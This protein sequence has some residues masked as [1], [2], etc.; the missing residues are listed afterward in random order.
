V[1]YKQESGIVCLSWLL[2]L[3]SPVPLDGV[4]WSGAQGHNHNHL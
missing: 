3:V 4:A 2:P 1:V